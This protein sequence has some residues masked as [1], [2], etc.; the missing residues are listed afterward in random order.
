[1]DEVTVMIENYGPTFRPGTWNDNV[2]AN[3]RFAYKRAGNNESTLT[4][5]EVWT[6]YY[7]ADQE[8]SSSDE[9]DP[10]ALA[11]M[12]ELELEKPE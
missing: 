5:Q 8:A 2:V 4:D 7:D 12:R 1:M 6:C 3:L 9:V 10:T 11:R